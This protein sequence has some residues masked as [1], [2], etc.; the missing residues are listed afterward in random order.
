VAILI[1]QEPARNLLPVMDEDEE[2]TPKRATLRDVAQAA[3]VSHTTVS[4][5]FARPDQLSVRLRERVLATARTLGYAGPDPAA[6]SLRTGRHGAIG[7]AFS[8]DLPY[9]FS[10]PTAIGFLQGVA[11][12]C[13][14]LRAN[15][16]LIA[17]RTRAEGD[18][19]VP[20][21]G[22]PTVRNAA[23]DGFILYSL[24]QD[25]PVVASVRVRGL[26]YIVV[27]QPRLPGVPFVGIDDEDTA[28]Q[29]AE[30][31]LALGHRCFAILSLKLVPDGSDGM[32]FPERI[33]AA[34]YAVPASRLAGYRTALVRGGIS[35]VTVPVV[36]CALNDEQRAR[37]LLLPLLLEAEQRPT[38]ILAMSDRLAWGA[39]AAARA[40]GLAVPGD[41][42]VVGFDDVVND[43]LGGSFLTT[44][45]QPHA[46]KGRVAVQMLTTRDGIKEHLL[47]AEL[48]VR[49]SS[50][51]VAMPLRGN[52]RED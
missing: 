7:L 3:G 4:N 23:V 29:V 41:L 40:A 42:S 30:H 32:A 17:T 8:E 33:A 36:E 15:L 46:E 13:R 12:A 1:G 18:D 51:Q 22:M 19:P 25:S 37:D 9:A 20:P 31:L 2:F 21:D 27:D 24:A 16:L 52:T 48:V 43:R 34:T 14:D 35:L 50:A 11:E 38:A 47:P 6:R 39:I 5:A 28:R 45:R 49:A 26:P 10:D 44:I